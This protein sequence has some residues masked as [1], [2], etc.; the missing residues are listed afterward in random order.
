MKTKQRFA[1]SMDYCVHETTATDGS[2]NAEADTGFFSST[3]FTYENVDYPTMMLIQGVLMKHVKHM[4]DDLMALGLSVSAALLAAPCESD[5]H[6]VKV[7]ALA[8]KK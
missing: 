4:L 1:I 8:S 3:P 5:E 7:G 2:I 6:G